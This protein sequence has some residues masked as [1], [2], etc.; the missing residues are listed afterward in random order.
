MARRAITLLSYQF[1]IGALCPDRSAPAKGWSPDAG[2]NLEEL[3]HGYA[4]SDVGGDR[5]ANR[6]RVPYPFHRQLIETARKPSMDE[7]AQNSHFISLS[8]LYAELRA[9]KPSSRPETIR[10]FIVGISTN[11]YQSGIVAYAVQYLES[12]FRLDFPERGAYRTP[13]EQNCSIPHDFWH[14]GLVSDHGGFECGNLC[15]DRH[16]FE[17]ELPT[18]IRSILYADSERQRVH[19]MQQANSIYF[20]RESVI[21]LAQDPEWQAWG[22]VRT[23]LKT[24]RPPEWKWDQLKAQLIIEAVR[25]PDLLKSGRAEIVAYVNE[26][27]QNERNNQRP[28]PW[29][30][31]QFVNMLRPLWTAVEST[32][33]PNETEN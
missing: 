5:S 32:A 15:G 6:K 11:T 19:L 9:M 8:D 18:R 13:L 3:S 12:Y 25:N 17:F 27:L 1:E 21:S 2:A 29:Q 4:L 31:Y 23:A 14:I 20:E 30:V 10:K 33:P 7:F 16:I 22:S 28:E 24:G 26:Y